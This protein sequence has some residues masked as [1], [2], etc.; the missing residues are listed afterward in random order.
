MIRPGT[1][2]SIAHVNLSQNFT[3]NERQTVLLIKNL[4]AAGVPQLLICRSGSLMLIGLKKIPNLK[5]LKVDSADPRLQGHM[6][7]GK[8]YRYVHAHDARGAEWALAHYMIYGTPYILSVRERKQTMGFL[9]KRALSWASTV[10]V[11]SE[12]MAEEAAR[13]TRGRVTVI[14]NSTSSLMPHKPSVLEIRKQYSNRFIAGM[15]APLIDRLKCQSVLIEAT[16]LLLKR[17]PTLVVL[18]IGEGPDKVKLQQK[19]KDLSN[20]KFISPGTGSL[21]DYLAALDAYVTPISTGDSYDTLNLLDAMDLQ[22]PV[23]T[24]Q[25]ADAKPYIRHLETAYVID[26]NNPDQLADVLTAFKKDELLKRRIVQGGKLEAMH[27]NPKFM[28]QAYWNLYKGL[29]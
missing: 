1:Q 9:I 21:P 13:L 22:V 14:P 18:L 10:A 20:V 27:A 17:F 2:L 29:H 8:H 15:A 24:T 7:V 16:R 25:Y 5:V 26:R 6:K 4:A 3:F 12:S 19:A 28:A 11:T 23:I